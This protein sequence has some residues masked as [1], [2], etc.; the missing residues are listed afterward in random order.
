MCMIELM[1]LGKGGERKESE[2]SPAL[3]FFF[4]ANVSSAGNHIIFWR[5]SWDILHF[6]AYFGGITLLAKQKVDE[7]K[8][9]LFLWRMNST[10]LNSLGLC[11]LQA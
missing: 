6:I 10:F 1:L 2:I 9:T 11:A 7:K 8:S 4:S 3:P 5:Y